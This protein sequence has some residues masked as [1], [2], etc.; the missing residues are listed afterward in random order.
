MSFAGAVMIVGFLAGFALL[1]QFRQHNAKDE[2][3]LLLASHR[4]NQQKVEQLVETTKTRKRVEKDYSNKTGQVLPNTKT[5]N[6]IS[7]P[8]L[9]LKQR[10][11]GETTPIKP[12]PTAIPKAISTPITKIA[13]FVET[14]DEAPEPIILAKAEKPKATPTKTPTPAITSKPT[15]TPI[16]TLAPTP[17]PTPKPTPTIA[18]TPKATQKPTP[19]PTPTPTPTPKPTP[20]MAPTPKATPIPTPAPTPISTPSV[21]RNISK[22]PSIESLQKWKEENEKKKE[23]ATPTPVKVATSTKS[24]ATKKSKINLSLDMQVRATLL[25]RFADYIEWPSIV[26]YSQSAPIQVCTFG[27]DSFVEYLKTQA[28]GKRTRSGRKFNLMQLTPSSDNDN[29]T[30]CQMLYLPSHL[31]RHAKRI[32]STIKNKPVLFITEN[33]QRGIIDFIIS[34]RRVKFAIDQSKAQEAG[35]RIGSVLV[36]LAV[37]KRS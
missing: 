17:I 6:N 4:K 2:Q 16:P 20:T 29:I 34:D 5:N 12:L 25:F 23:I 3:N 27:T 8:N 1:M 33:T 13:T 21:Q 35:I 32:S 15:P 37:E 11:I 26:F 19:A 30:H 10:P 22:D 14:L 36:D 7:K 9:H 31:S 28:S 24:Q 18:P